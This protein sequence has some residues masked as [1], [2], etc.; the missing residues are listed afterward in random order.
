MF[1]FTITVTISAVVY[2]YIYKTS[3]IIN[4]QCIA[5]TLVLNT[6]QIL[7]L[8]SPNL[9]GAPSL[10]ELGKRRERVWQ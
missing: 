8:H 5:I 2:I 1:P 9:E 6:C 10:V 4:P 3:Y 7:S